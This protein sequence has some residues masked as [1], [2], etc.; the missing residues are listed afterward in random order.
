LLHRR[1]VATEWVVCSWVL[2]AETAEK[3]RENLVAL[4]LN[5]FVDCPKAVVFR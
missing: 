4:R 5:H 1:R 3:A 2:G